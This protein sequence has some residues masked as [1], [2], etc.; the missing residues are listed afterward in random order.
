MPFFTAD[1]VRQALVYLPDST[2]PRSSAS[3]RCWEQCLRVGNSGHPF[4]SMQETELMR[5][6]FASEG[7]PPERLFYVPFGPQKAN[8]TFWKPRENA[9][10]SLLHHDDTGF[11][12]G[13]NG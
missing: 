13:G 11:S 12:G 2:H 10:K 9:G 3:W 6:Y 1:H 4:G 8:S 5:D 7:G